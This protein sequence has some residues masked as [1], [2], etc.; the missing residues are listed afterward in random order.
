MLYCT[1]FILFCLRLW[2]ATSLVLRLPQGRVR[3]HHN[4][5]ASQRMKEL[6]DVF[7]G[8]TPLTRVDKNETLQREYKRSYGELS[9]VSRHT[10][11]RVLWEPVIP[12]FQA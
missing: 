10:I 3:T 2:H 4:L 1:L 7:G 8:A 5:A 6:S 12:D 9:L 11:H